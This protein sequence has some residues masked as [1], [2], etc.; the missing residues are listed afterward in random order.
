MLT[1]SVVGATAKRVA[2]SDSINTYSGSAWATIGLLRTLPPQPSDE[3][4]GKK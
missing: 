2:K 1:R 4:P 3:Q